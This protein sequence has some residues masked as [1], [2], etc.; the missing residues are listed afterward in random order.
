MK[1]K[2]KG[3]ENEVKVKMRWKLL[4]Q[5][6]KRGTQKKKEGENTNTW[7][8]AQ[9]GQTLPCK[10]LAPSTPELRAQLNLTNDHKRKKTTPK[11]VNLPGHFIMVHWSCMTV[12]LS[13]NSEKEGV[14]SQLPAMQ[15][16]QVAEKW[17][18]QVLRHI[19]QHIDIDRWDLEK[20]PAVSLYLNEL[21]IQKCKFRGNFKVSILCLDKHSWRGSCHLDESSMNHT[22]AQKHLCE[23]W[24][25][26]HRTCKNTSCKPDMTWRMTR[27][28]KQCKGI[29]G[30]SLLEAIVP[31]EPNRDLPNGRVVFGLATSQ[32]RNDMIWKLAGTS[33]SAPI[34]ITD[35]TL[36]S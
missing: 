22:L 33:M 18:G 21:L 8:L 24:C 3:N 17:R 29:L 36:A 20:R 14:L 34:G 35:D 23:L 12:K 30:T 27:R 32:C 26:M 25:G 6:A 28:E 15:R 13:S 1:M 16:L 10:R 4:N 9:N 7:N 5:D 11:V 19:V 31:S 2:K